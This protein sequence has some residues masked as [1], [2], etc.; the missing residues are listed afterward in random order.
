[1]RSSQEEL[2]KQLN[3]LEVIVR[4]T[5][6]TGHLILA[7]LIG[8]IVN[9]LAPLVVGSFFYARIIPG[10]C[11]LGSMLLFFLIICMLVHYERTKKRGRVLYEEL[12][13]ELQW[14]ITNDSSVSRRVARDPGIRARIIL[15]SFIYETAL[16][17]LP[18]H[19]GS[20]VYLTAGTLLLFWTVWIDST[21]GRFLL[22]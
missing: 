16:P 19:I 18:D 22:H 3:R 13:D 5:A 4:A 20:F 21:Y 10:V 14:R 17:F 8:M 1:M 11:S 9:A 15:R 6:M 12:S 2:G 7:T